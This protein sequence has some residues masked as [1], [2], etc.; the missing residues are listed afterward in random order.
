MPRA[1][2]AQLFDSQYVDFVED[3]PFWR[4]IASRAGDAILEV[5]CGSGR[6]LLDLAGAGYDM[7]G[8]DVDGEM[9]TILQANRPPDLPG[10]IQLHKADLRLL[11]LNQRFSAILIPCNLFSYFG[12]EDA[13]EALQAIHRH[14]LP[15]GVLAM[16]L[17]N[18]PII[19]RDKHKD[20]A[21]LDTFTE[22]SLGLPVQV[23]ARQRIRADRR[24]VDV[25]WNYDILH[26]D[27]KVERVTAA[28]SYHMRTPADIHQLL[29]K[30]ALHLEAVYG[31]Y[32]RQIYTS[33][34]PRMLVTAVPHGS[35]GKEKR[36]A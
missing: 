20:D 36:M 23:S 34:S 17:P 22:R 18:T 2:F 15:D 21:V 7:T 3:L 11:K 6:V 26:A 33:S 4:Y 27:G 8:V 16:D 12:D 14:L 30:S 13:L 31:G 24:R 28:R 19:L 32:Q 25:E 10:K 1:A 5:G 29:H 35:Q 9:L